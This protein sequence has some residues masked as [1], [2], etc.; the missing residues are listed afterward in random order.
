MCKENF[1]AKSRRLVFFYPFKFFFHRLHYLKCLF[2][3]QLVAKVRMK[4]LTSASYYFLKKLAIRSLIPFNSHQT[5]FKTQNLRE[6]IQE[7]F[8][9]YTVV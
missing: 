7:Q 4:F 2:F 6:L 5:T 1:D 9:T 8:E 3:N